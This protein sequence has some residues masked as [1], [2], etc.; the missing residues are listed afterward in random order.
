MILYQLRC[1]REHEFEAWF[2]DSAS[3]DQQ[4]KR[5]DI[6]CPM[7][8]DANISKAPMAPNLGKGTRKESVDSDDVSI[9]SVEKRAREVARQ[10]LNN[11]GKL[12]EAIEDNCE[13]VGDEFAEEARRIHYGD[14]EERGIY[15]RA[16]EKETVELDEEGIEVY[17]IPGPPRRND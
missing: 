15:G 17:R 6:D 9:D 8:G 4:H 12:R 10:I 14:A 2:R 3:Y 7:C 13:Y 16:T 1:G 11:A 5:G